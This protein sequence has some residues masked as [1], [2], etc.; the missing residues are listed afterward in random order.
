MTIWADI[1]TTGVHNP[2]C[3]VKELIYSVR[4]R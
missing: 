4:N 2:T 1:F 3:I